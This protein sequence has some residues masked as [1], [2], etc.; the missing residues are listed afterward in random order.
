MIYTKGNLIKSAIAGDYDIIIHGA[1]CFNV[2]GSGIARQIRDQTPDAWLADQHTMAGDRNKLGNYTIGM[3]GRLVIIN[4]YT[5]YG[6][7]RNGA[8]NDLFEYDAF[9]QVLT[10]IAERFGKWRIGVPHIGMGLAAGDPERIIPMLEHF[11]TLVDAQGGS[12][13]LMEFAEG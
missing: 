3:H 2:M 13:S 7:N 9:E 11:S 1:N 8:Q 5:Q 10:K 12:V 6:M 4:A